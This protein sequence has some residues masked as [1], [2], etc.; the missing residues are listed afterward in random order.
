MNAAIEASGSNPDVSL[1]VDVNHLSRSTPN[2][3]DRFVEF[4][5]DRGLL[6]LLVPLLA[7]CWWMLRRQ[8]AER[9]GAA[10]S[11][12][13]LLWAPLA[14]SLALLV[15]LPIKDFVERQRPFVDH[16]EVDVLA[17]GTSGFSF[18]SDH[19]TLAMAVGAAL[20]V[21]HRGFGLAAIGIALLE[22]AS[23]V[24]L[25]VSYP[26]DVVGG[27]ALGTA[28]ALLFAPA[29]SALLTPLM[30]RAARSPRLGRL[31]SAPAAAGADDGGRLE[32]PEPRPEMRS[33][34]GSTERDLAA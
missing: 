14:A 30:K 3:F 11:M 24:Y 26:S 18:V 20:F 16:T 4:A 15:N 21:A 32:L 34:G 19:A 8:P 29:A 5:G 31:V 2:W 1:L 22:G 7:A 13:A 9:G 25:G 28:V 23:R 10:A 6:L 27:F 33:G 12:A 17:D